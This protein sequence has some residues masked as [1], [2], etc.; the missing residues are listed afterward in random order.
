VDG[1]EQEELLRTFDVKEQDDAAL[2]YAE[3]IRF[4]VIQIYMRA[5]AALKH[6][7]S[8]AIAVHV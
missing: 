3:Q 5:S 6:N 8:F 7:P 2:T 1:D 4:V